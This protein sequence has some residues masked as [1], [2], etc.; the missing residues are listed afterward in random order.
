MKRIV[1]LSLL[2]C[3]LF[4]APGYGQ[5][6]L[7]DVKIYGQN[8]LERRNLKGHVVS[9]TTKTYAVKESFGEW[10]TGGCCLSRLSIFND[11]GNYLFDTSGRDDYITVDGIS[12]TFPIVQ[13]VS[14]Y[15]YDES[16][17][18]AY[19]DY[20]S[21]GGVFEGLNDIEWYVAARRSENYVD[22]Y[23]YNS[24]G[25]IKS[26]TN[27]RK[28]AIGHDS[29]R[30]LGVAGKQ[31]YK[32]DDNGYEIWYYS[33]N[34]SRYTDRSYIFA[35]KERNVYSGDGQ[36]YTVRS[37]NDKGQLIE[38]GRIKRGAIVS[39]RGVSGGVIND[40]VY[41]EY[42]E[43][44]DLLAKS[45]DAAATKAIKGLE[46]LYPYIEDKM[47]SSSIRF[48]GYEYDSAGN[49]TVQKEYR[50]R[51]KEVIVN[52]WT[53]R[54]I[55]YSGENLSGQQ[56]V[57]GFID[58][59]ID[60]IDA[61]NAKIKAEEEW[62]A[63]PKYAELSDND[64]SSWEALL[65]SQ[66]KLPESSTAL[67]AILAAKGSSLKIEIP[68]TI[69]S[70]GTVVTPVTIRNIQWSL[71]NNK[72]YFTDIKMRKEEAEAKV[73]V[74]E[75]LL[76]LLSDLRSSAPKGSPGKNLQPIRIDILITDGIIAME[77]SGSGL[78]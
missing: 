13:G 62:K 76:K 15:S 4:A 9:V 73:Q 63:L 48:Y 49:W 72:S 57:D 54:E 5:G 78:M 1:F 36:S 29:E 27:E 77:Q 68:V 47:N 40:K 34:G 17:R 8:D 71:R 6:D 50:I 30:L 46:Y 37:Y 44:G 11:D 39:P 51:G 45:I 67:G 59:A 35:K 60:A 42:N 7:K 12:G 2:A 32:Y 66:I 16:G 41:Y 25:N 22:Y 28:S 43:H 61:E 24:D 55:V 20:V 56:I 10:T 58:A 33:G 18:I 53:E 3:V 23:E 38:Q 74:E 69:S 26:I 14:L 19:V 52:R 64:F 70:D 31:I 75:M 65:K 21:R